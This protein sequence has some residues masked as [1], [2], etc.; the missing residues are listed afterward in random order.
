MIEQLVDNEKL[1]ETGIFG[2]ALLAES[3]LSISALTILGHK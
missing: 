2:A 1:S 3:S